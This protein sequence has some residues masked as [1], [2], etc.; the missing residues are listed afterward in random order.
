[1]MSG[2][3]PERNL[4][5]V[6][7]VKFASKIL[8]APLFDIHITGEYNIPRKGSFILLPKHQRWED[9]PI[10]AVSVHRHLLYVAKQELF[11]NVISRNIISILGGMPLDRDKPA[12]SRNT[13]SKLLKKINENEGIVLFPEGTY[14]RDRM[15]TGHVGLLRMIHSSIN[16]QFI[17][18]GIRYTPG[19]RR[20]GV[21]IS[22]GKP[23]PGID[24]MNSG[25]LL[26]YIMSEIAR[27]S[28]YCYT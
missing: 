28:G 12:R 2:Y 7:Y 17:P 5:A 21:N 13:Y 19:R 22:F 26:E 11:N 16:T 25:E 14:Y 23:V 6:K 18:A 3:Y 10:T 15:G 24:F 27:L 1:M 20:T 4:T 9:I 8:F